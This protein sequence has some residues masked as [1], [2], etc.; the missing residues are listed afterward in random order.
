MRD[1]CCSFRNN[2]GTN[3]SHEPHIKLEA[4]LF[5]V[6]ICLVGLLCQGYGTFIAF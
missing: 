5:I 6:Q 1:I 2:C 4:C 3:T